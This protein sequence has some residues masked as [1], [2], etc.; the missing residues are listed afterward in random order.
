MPKRPSQ[1]PLEPSSEQQKRKELVT[2]PLVFCRSSLFSTATELDIFYNEK[3]IYSTGEWSVFFTG[4]HLRQRDLEVWLACLRLLKKCGVQPGEVL[5]TTRGK[6]LRE[7]GVSRPRGEQV[8]EITHRLERL[9]IALVKV[10]GPI[11]IQR[12]HLLVRFDNAKEEDGKIELEIDPIF[13][14]LLENYTV[15][16]SLENSLKLKRSMSKWLF[17]YAMTCDGEFKIGVKKLR[18]LSGNSEDIEYL[19][20]KTKQLVRRGAKPFNEFRRVLNE[21]ITEILAT[22]PDDFKGLQLVDGGEDDE[23][24][25]VIHLAS[26]PKILINTNQKAAQAQSQRS[27]RRPATGWGVVL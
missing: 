12:R 3:Q 14:P 25:V 26:R 22:V 17:R 6:I 2:L 5:R 24:Q 1:Q 19:D 21:A 9:M 4:F 23:G 16:A 10:E 27:Q 7:M 20:Q 18:D 13:A 11:S 8:N 15:G